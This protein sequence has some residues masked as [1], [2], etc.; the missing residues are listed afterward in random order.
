VG[1]QDNIHPANKLDVGLRLARVAL[2]QTYGEKIK[3]AGPRLRSMQ[4]E[5][6]QIRIT[7]AH[8]EG[9]AARGSAARGFAIAGEDRRFVWAS[10]RI[11][12]ASVIVSSPGVDHPVAVRYAWADNP[13]ELNLHNAAGLPAEPFRTDHWPPPAK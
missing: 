7:F 4:I 8:A 1:D 6:S 9:L 2:A 13:G 11:D 10:A 3:D 12:G 5:G